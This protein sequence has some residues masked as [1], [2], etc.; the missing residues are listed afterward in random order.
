MGETAAVVSDPTDSRG[1]VCVLP[2]SVPVSELAVQFAELIQFPLTGPQQERIGYGLVPKR[3]GALD[4]DTSLARAGVAEPLE[5]RLVPELTI[6]A[7]E[8]S[9][10]NNQ[11]EAPAEATPARVR[12]LEERSL[13]EEADLHLRPE[14][15]IDAA[16]H[17]EIERFASRDRLVECGGLLLGAV[18]VERKA[19]FI[20]IQAIAPALGAVETRS[21]FT[22]TFDAWKS[23]LDLRDAEH[24]ELRILGWFHTHPGWGVF[25]SEMDLFVQE[26]F[27]SHPDMVACVLDP[28]SGKAGFFCWKDGRV[29]ES[30]TYTLVGSPARAVAG[31]EVRRRLAVAAVGGVGAAIAAA[32][33]TGLAPSRLPQ[34]KPPPEHALREKVSARTGS[35]PVQPV[36][37]SQTPSSL[38]Q[39]GRPLRGD[40]IIRHGETLWEIC[41]RAYGDGSLGAALGRYNGI[42]DPTSL[43][44]GRK[45]TIPEERK[46]K[47][48]ER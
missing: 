17:R 26:H 13:V 47:E 9:P 34:M 37:G 19:R 8:S 3:G 38:A 40:Y 20:H 5:L 25:L 39:P 28:S 15:A 16:A 46:L 18:E 48:L 11:D 32:L 27:F 6:G 10:P 35:G 44:V 4:P 42:S 45:I 41:R 36:G 12:I 29:A 31:R 21:S 33:Y 43:Q 14:V 2:D 30:R 24:P 22:L 1:F 23:M 7:E